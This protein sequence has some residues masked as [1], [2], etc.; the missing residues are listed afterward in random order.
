MPPHGQKPKPGVAT[1]LTP[2]LVVRDA[3]RAIDFYRRAFGAE[4]VLRLC[5]PDGEIAHAELRLGEA[6]LYLNEEAREEQ[7][8][9]P[10]SLGGAA[11]SLHL[12]VPDVDVAYARAVSAGAMPRARVEDMFWGER[13][14][15]V[16]DPFGHEW[17]LATRTEKLS[18]DEIRARAQQLVEEATSL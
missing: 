7:E 18:P 6:S 17:A 14:G 13:Y 2:H 9:S 11:V 8:L 10:E 3:A 5:G 15:T 1:T 12:Y 16:R 4:E